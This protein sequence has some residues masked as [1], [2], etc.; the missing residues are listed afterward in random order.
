M[1]FSTTSYS[2]PDK[3]GFATITVTRSGDRERGVREVSDGNGW[4]G[5]PGIPG[6]DYVAIDTPQVLT[7]GAG[8][9]SK[10]FQVQILG[11]TVVNGSKTV[12]LL[13]SEPGG[14]A[15]LG[16]P[17]AATLTI[18]NADQGGSLKFSTSAYTVVEAAGPAPITVIRTGGLASDVTVH[19]AT[20]D[21]TAV[22]G[23]DYTATSGVLTFGSG[24]M[25]Q[26][27]TVTV[28][29]NPLGQRNRTIKLTLSD[30]DGGGALSSPSTAVLTIQDAQDG[31]QFSASDYTVNEAG[32]ATITVTRNSPLGTLQ[33]NFATGDGTAVESTDYTKNSRH[34]GLRRRPDHQD[35][36]CLDTE[37]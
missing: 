4:H 15:T 28:N 2:A 22:A 36:L 27:F 17:I 18:T 13:L 8:E 26:T 20:S 24:V 33:V 34:P 11:N 32:T 37:Q 16:N 29:N 1:N 12:S 5:I 3:P 19:F 35:V 21:G 23:T 9:T 25:S 14:G 30:P 31:I 10:A 6:T 7:F